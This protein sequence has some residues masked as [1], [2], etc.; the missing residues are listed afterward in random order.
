MRLARRVRG[1]PHWHHLPIP[2]ED[3]TNQR[4]MKIR[5]CNAWG[6]LFSKRKQMERI[7]LLVR[8]MSLKETRSLLLWEDLIKEGHDFTDSDHVRPQLTPFIRASLIS[9]VAL[10]NPTLL[11]WKM[12]IQLPPR[13]QH[14]KEF[15][16]C[17]WPATRFR[18]FELC[19][20]W[21]HL[22]LGEQYLILRPVGS[23]L[24]FRAL[25]RCFD[26]VGMCS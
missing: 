6:L 18:T 5:L 20:N 26:R 16:C 23:C 2:Q 4:G 24:L 3:R 7:D 12:T 13:Y 8:V 19:L 21:T 10:I 22:L 11:A 14:G 9:R 1:S 17:Q 25:D 15:N